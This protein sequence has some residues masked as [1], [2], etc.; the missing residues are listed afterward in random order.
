M[1]LVGKNDLQKIYRMNIKEKN[2]CKTLDHKNL[3]TL[4]LTSPQRAT[5]KLEYLRSA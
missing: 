5:Y 3:K 2:T 4:K 1:Q